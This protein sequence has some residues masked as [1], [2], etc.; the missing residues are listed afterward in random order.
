MSF[1][2]KPASAVNGGKDVRPPAPPSGGLRRTSMLSA[3]FLRMGARTVM[4]GKAHTAPMKIAKTFPLGK[5]LGVI[6]MDASPGMLEDDEYG[7]EWEAGPG[8]SL[9]VTNQSF[10]KVHPCP[11]GGEAKL[12]QSFRIGEGAIVQHMPEP[13][14]LYGEAA[15]DS[16]TVVRL[17]PGAV[18]MQAEVLCPGRARR[19]ELFR[20]RKLRNKLTVY[21][22]DELIF[23]QHQ[24]VEPRTRLLSAI[25]A[26][27]DQTHWG[28]FYLFAEGITAAHAEAVRE[29]LRA[30]TQTPGRKAEYGVT[31]TYRNG[32]AVL[33]SAQAAWPL[34]ALL[35]RAWQSARKAVLGLEPLRFPK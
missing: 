4:T 23:S 35:E 2:G 12:R 13:V 24:R 29:A 19:G 9:Y 3:S 26:W 21:A 22:G 1:A 18:W 11:G 5:A 16:E 7:M 15:L 28:S 6:V 10:M 20:Y 32:L 25:G 27:E 17:A 14:M 31:L 30:Y 8:A 33:A 34:Q